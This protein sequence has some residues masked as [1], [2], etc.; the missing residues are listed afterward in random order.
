MGHGDQSP[1][2]K[3]DSAPWWIGALAERLYNESKSISVEADLDDE[4]FYEEFSLANGAPVE[5]P[6]IPLGE[7]DTDDPMSG[8]PGKL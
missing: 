2:G 7:L 6:H 5:E 4:P 8:L 1:V 3:E